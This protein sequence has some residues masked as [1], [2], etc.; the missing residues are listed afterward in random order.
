[1]NQRIKALWTAR[2]RDPRTQQGRNLLTVLK[3][4][5][6]FQCCL[7]VLCEI[8]REEGIVEGIP[9]PA[10]GEEIMIVYRAVDDHS[11]RSNVT[12]PQA[13]QAWAELS[14]TEDSPFPNYGGRDVIDA[15]TV[16]NDVARLS[17]PDIADEIDERL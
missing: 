8:A 3:D 13:V 7:G 4:G 14:V 9:R 17:F 5:G 10:W 15:L 1:M 6:T 11:D 16:I 12:L 2:L